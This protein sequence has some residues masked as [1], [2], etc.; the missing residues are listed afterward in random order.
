M[1]DETIREVEQKP[2]RYLLWS[3][4]TFVE[5]GVPKFGEDFDRP[6]GDYLRSHYRRVGFLNPQ[7]VNIYSWKV[8]VWERLPD[9]TKATTAEVR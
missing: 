1:T 7:D 3:N 2:V 8:T 4:R 9:E 5:Y 6:F